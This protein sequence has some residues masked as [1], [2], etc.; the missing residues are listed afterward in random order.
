MTKN[1]SLPVGPIYHSELHNLCKMTLVEHLND[2]LHML[3]DR[4]NRGGVRTYLPAGN[5][6]R[7][8]RARRLAV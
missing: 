6:E 4:P 5:L 7:Q 3:K 8:W 1:T 2:V